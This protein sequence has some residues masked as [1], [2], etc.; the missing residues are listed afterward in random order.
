MGHNGRKL[1]AAHLATGA[2][3]WAQGITRALGGDSDPPV[4]QSFLSA[5][6]RGSEATAQRAIETREQLGSRLLDEFTAA[7]DRLHEVLSGLNA[8]DWDK[9]CFHRRGPMPVHDYVALRLQELTMHGW[10]MRSGLDESA[11]LWEEPLPVLVN[12]V[13]RWLR[14]AF[15]PG[16]GLPTPMRFRFEVPG[17]VPVRQDV[18]INHDSFQF[19]PSGDARAD[20]TIHCDTSS[21]I[22]LIY[23]RLNV[24]WAS[25]QGKVTID[26]R[27]E[28]ATNFTTWFRGF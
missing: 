14:N 12:M 23:G 26:G 16:L 13:P 20:V 17:P 25:V 21:Y 28:Q 27:R 2:D 22:L 6:Q 7:Y 9:P 15:S 3:T 24:D 1:S 5:G 18:L 4:G 11:E 10:D 19:E 8:E